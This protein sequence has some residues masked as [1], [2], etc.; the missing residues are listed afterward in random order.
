VEELSNNDGENGSANIN[1][2]ESQRKLFKEKQDELE[3]QIEEIQRQLE[4]S[5]EE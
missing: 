1:S 3:K 2:L 4:I 5:Q